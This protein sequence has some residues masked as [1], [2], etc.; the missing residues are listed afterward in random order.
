MAQK[1]IFVNN[2]TNTLQ[3]VDTDKK[4]QGKVLFLPERYVHGIPQGTPLGGYM[5]CKILFSKKFT[6]PAE[7]YVDAEIFSLDDDSHGKRVVGFRCQ[8]MQAFSETSVT[9]KIFIKNEDKLDLAFLI[10]GEQNFKGVISIRFFLDLGFNNS[11][12]HS[13]FP[14]YLEK[15]R[16]ESNQTKVNITVDERKV[17]HM[18]MLKRK[19]PTP[20]SGLTSPIDFDTMPLNNT[21]PDLFDKDLLEFTEDCSWD[22][23]YDTMDL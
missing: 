10:K 3:R 22:P 20:S 5:Q 4:F 15:K 6:G 18:M 7:L 21:L 14:F 8:Q 23:N 12:H 19:P 11:I 9:Q 17:L 2:A 16:L 13:L 1:F